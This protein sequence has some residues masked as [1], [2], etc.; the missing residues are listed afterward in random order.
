MTKPRKMKI[1]FIF[2]CIHIKKLWKDS[3]ATSNSGY[4]WKRWWVEIEWMEWGCEEKFITYFHF[5]FLK[6]YSKIDFLRLFYRV[7]SIL[8]CI[9]LYNTTVVRI[10]N[11]SIIPKTS[12][13]FSLTSSLPTTFNPWQWLS[14][15][16]S[17]VMLMEL[18]GIYPFETAVLSSP[19]NITSLGF[20]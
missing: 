12:C 1:L 19:M 7:L 16:L 20:I 18:Y 2:A 4:L 9:D 3:W 5:L 10:P 17:Y 15:S 14:N 11:N 13:A 8:T 6:L